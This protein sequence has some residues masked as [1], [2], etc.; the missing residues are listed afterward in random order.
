MS[1][2]VSMTMIEEIFLIIILNLVNMSVMGMLILVLMII[3]VVVIVVIV[4]SWL[5]MVVV[6]FMMVMMIMMIVMMMLVLSL[7][8]K[9]LLQLFLFFFFLFAS[10]FLLLDR[11][12]F[13]LFIF[14]LTLLYGSMLQL[15]VQFMVTYRMM[16]GVDALFSPPWSLFIAAVIRTAVFARIG[17]LLVIF[18]FV[19]LYQLGEEVFDTKSF[20]SVAPQGV[21]LR[22][23]LEGL[24]GHKDSGHQGGYLQHVEY[25][26]KSFGVV[27]D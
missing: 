7:L 6:V 11:L 4:M 3:V 17:I 27:L 23:E 18:F 21:S 12:L 1:V 8:L 22:L 16:D 14:S 2:I 25:L 20:T 10:L 5:V 15:F 26:R 13:L 9:L 24:G 19:S